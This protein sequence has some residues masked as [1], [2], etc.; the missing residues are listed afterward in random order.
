[1]TALMASVSAWPAAFTT[2]GKVA[3]ELLHAAILGI[4]EPINRLMAHTDRMPFKAHATR[5]VFRR[6]SG[7]KAVFNCSLK[8]RMHNHLSMDHP[9]LF[10]LILRDQSLIAIQ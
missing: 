10:I 6:P 1:M 5:A 8:L 4:R 3:T 7:F 9:T 2:F